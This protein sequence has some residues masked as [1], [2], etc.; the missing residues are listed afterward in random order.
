[1]QSFQ[2]ISVTEV[3]EKLDK[4]AIADIRDSNSFLAG[5]MEGAVNLSN[6][7]LADFMATTPKEQP[8]VVVCYHGI[9]SQQAALF[10]VDQGYTEVFSMDGGFE[11]WRL[12]QKVVS[13]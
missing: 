10:L 5:H 9:S 13:E 12:S 8:V 6:D 1:M 7:N 2:H 4:M 11:G 3:A